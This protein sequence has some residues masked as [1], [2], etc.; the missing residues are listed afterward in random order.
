MKLDGIPNDVITNLNPFSLVILIPLLD[1]AV[2]PFMRKMRIN[3]TPIKKIT[4][5]YVRPRSPPRLSA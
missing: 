2:Y 4:A 3:F 5:G 1:L